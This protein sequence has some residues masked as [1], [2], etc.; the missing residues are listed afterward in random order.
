MEKKFLKTKEA[1]SETEIKKWEELVKQKFFIYE[2][3]KSVQE[4]NDEDEDV[5][6]AD[7]KKEI[8]KM[9]EEIKKG[10]DQN[11]EKREYCNRTA[12]LRLAPDCLTYKEAVLWEKFKLITSIKELED[13]ENYEYKHHKKETE[14]EI[15]DEIGD[16][17]DKSLA[18]PKVVDEIK[19]DIETV[20]ENFKKWGRAAE[21]E[22]MLRASERELMEKFLKRTLFNEHPRVAF[23]WDLMGN[24]IGDK[25]LILKAK[26]DLKMMGCADSDLR[27]IKNQ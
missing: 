8:N 5:L 27:E 17:V 9:Q 24:R 2:N 21:L 6:F 26:E 18:D 20:K 14:Q 11:P 4:I 12:V 10:L 25:L 3:Y 16:K 15:Y 19:K 7:F 1:P 23:G 22:K 13:F